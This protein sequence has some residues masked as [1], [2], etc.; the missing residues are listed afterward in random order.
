MLDWIIMKSANQK[1]GLR[2][3]ALG[4]A[5]FLVQPVFATEM[6]LKMGE[7]KGE[8]QDKVHREEIDVLAW[9]WGMTQST[10]TTTGGAGAGKVNVRQ[11]HLTKR[12]DRSTPA[13]MLLC[14]N[15][16]HEDRAVLTLRKQGE[17][18]VEFYRVVLED[19]MV[20]AVSTGGSAGGDGLIETVALGFARVGIE[21]ISIKP[22]GEP[23]EPG[24]FAWDVVNNVAG[25]VTF[26]GD[27]P[28]PPP[29]DADED[30]LPDDWELAYGLDTAVNNAGADADADGATDYEEFIAG[31]NPTNPDEVLKAR[32][33]SETG[34]GTLT[35]SSVSG[36]QYR[37]LLTPN[38]DQPFVEYTVVPS[39][40]QGSTSIA[41]PGGS[42]VNFFRIEVLP[43]Q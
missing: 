11:L 40:G 41:V 16:K 24:R 19:V 35:W 26:P 2:W 28:P 5:A 38:L 22:T 29:I 1:L 31:T 20:N 32:L 9:S 43:A 15:G 30:G 7:I 42:P 33:D 34:A 12:T 6:F 39:A 23:D 21:Y 36:K 37:V 4:A 18:A 3:L 27:N 8:S 17:T 13:L 14:A 10:A 25:G